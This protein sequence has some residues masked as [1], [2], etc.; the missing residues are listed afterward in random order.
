MIYNV[1]QNLLNGKIRQNRGDSS[2]RFI[3]FNYREQDCNMYRERD[4]KRVK[5]RGYKTPSF[6]KYS[7]KISVAEPTISTQL[8]FL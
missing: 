2:S 7:S 4:Y 5:F 6:F 1:T 3:F 8:R